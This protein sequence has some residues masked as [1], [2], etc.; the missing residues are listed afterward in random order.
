MVNITN[1]TGQLD[2]TP[3][4]YTS[5]RFPEISD[6]TGL[7]YMYIYNNFVTGEDDKA[8]FLLPAIQLCP[9]NIWFFLCN[10]SE[11]VMVWLG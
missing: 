11:K 2:L 4:I 10:T 6:K 7:I 1:Y 3:L 9:Q 5:S 8:V